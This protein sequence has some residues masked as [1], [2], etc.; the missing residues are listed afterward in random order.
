MDDRFQNVTT[1]LDA[2]AELMSKVADAEF[3]N[4]VLNFLSRTAKIENFGAFYFANLSRPKPVLSVSAGRMSR[5]IFQRDADQILGDLA[6]QEG[7]AT[8]IRQAP[9]GGVLIER[10]HPTDDDPRQALYERSRVLE[11]VAVSSRLGRGG[12]RSFF[13]RS[14]SDGWM[15]DAEYAALCQ[16]LPFV[17]ELIGLR[18]RIV[19]AEN[20]H[21]SAQ[22]N[23]S[24]LRERNAPGFVL[25]SRR[26]AECCDCLIA[27]K[28][29]AGTALDLGVA[30]TTVRTLR[31]RAYR[32]L[33][34]SSAA[35]VMALLINDGV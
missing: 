5:Y 21:F 1:Q 32:K 19:G 18:H 34:V 27:G 22:R 25:L 24:S 14:K 13:L 33:E 11:R 30:E 8:Q 16:I 12:F 2:Q 15:N 6:M 35:Q 3:G 7:F 26:E 17:H 10:W 20:F 9:R 28:T 23:V 4:A 29:V 31:R